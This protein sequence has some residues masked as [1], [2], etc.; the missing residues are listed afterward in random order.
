MNFQ[1]GQFWRTSNGAC[2][3]VVALNRDGGCCAE[4]A[5]G[6]GV[7]LDKNGCVNGTLKSGFDLVA[8]IW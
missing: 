2:L 1:I 4:Y 3:R 6:I 8:R 7:T 5:H